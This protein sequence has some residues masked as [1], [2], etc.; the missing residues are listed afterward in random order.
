MR[1]HGID[2]RAFTLVELLVVIAII[3]VMVGLL[4]PAVQAARES[5]RRMQCSNN[6]KQLGL[7]F[8]NYESTH[9]TFPHGSLGGTSSLPANICGINWRVSLLPFLEQ[10]NVYDQLSFSGESVSGH[11]SYPFSGGAVVLKNFSMAGFLCP[12]SDL[13]PFVDAPN[14]GNTHGALMHHY[15]GISGATP[16]PALPVRTNVCVASMRG[17]I[18]NNGMLPVNDK[19]GFKSCRDGT[20]N[21][22]MVAEQSGLVGN[23]DIRSNYTGGWS[24]PAER[25]MKIPN[26]PAGHNF[27]GNGQTTVKFA[28]NTQLTTPN[29]SSQPYENN[30]ILNSFHPGGIQVL[31]VDGSVMFLAE[32]IQMLTLLRLSAKN[33]GEVVGDF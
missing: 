16:D 13:E 11:T 18:C 20:S 31:L 4:L 9:K 17:D 12:S 1:S 24:G 25:T 3:G 8:H 33:D 2:R 6:L 7:A 19:S 30:T 26:V 15:V 28:I 14:T 27:Y 23:Q 32:N 5:A 21:T 22:I 29:A 10:S